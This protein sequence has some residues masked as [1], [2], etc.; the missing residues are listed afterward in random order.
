[1]E[2]LQTAGVIAGI[3]HAPIESQIYD[4][5]R[6]NRATITVDE[7][8]IVS[9]NDQS[10]DTTSAE[11]SGSVGAEKMGKL[12]EDTPEAAIAVCAATSRRRE[13]QN[14]SGAPSWWEGVASNREAHRRARFTDAP[15]D[16]AGVAAEMHAAALPKSIRDG[17]AGLNGGASVTIDGNALVDEDLRSLPDS[18]VD[19]G[20]YKHLSV[21]ETNGEDLIS[22]PFSGDR[23]LPTRHLDS[24]VKL[25][26]SMDQDSDEWA[27]ELAKS[28]KR[29]AEKFDNHGHEEV[30]NA[31]SD[32][33]DPLGRSPLAHTKQGRRN[34]LRLPS[35]PLRD[36]PAPTS[37][38]KDETDESAQAL[39]NANG[40][41]PHEE[42]VPTPSEPSLISS[43][44]KSLFVDDPGEWAASQG[45]EVPAAMLLRPAAMADTDSTSRART[46][47]LQPPGEEWAIAGADGKHRPQRNVERSPKVDTPTKAE[48]DQFLPPLPET[49]QN[50]NIVDECCTE[51]PETG[52]S[53]GS[54]DDDAEIA[55]LEAEV[56]YLQAHRASLESQ[57]ETASRSMLA[58][59]EPTADTIEKPTT[60]DSVPS[61]STTQVASQTAVPM[62]SDLFKANTGDVNSWADVSK[63][64]EGS[65]AP[66]AP[67]VYDDSGPLWSDSFAAYLKEPPRALPAEPSDA[68]DDDAVE[69][70]K[71]TR[72]KKKRGKSKRSSSVSSTTSRPSGT[73][74][75]FADYLKES[76][77]I[78]TQDPFGD[79][80]DDD[81]NDDGTV[82]SKTSAKELSALADELPDLMPPTPL[83]WSE[84]EKRAAYREAGLII[85]EPVDSVAALQSTAS[86]KED[87]LPSKSSSWSFKDAK[88]RFAQKAERAALE[89]KEKYETDFISPNPFLYIYC[90]CPRYFVYSCML[91]TRYESF[92]IKQLR[93]DKSVIVTGAGTNRV[94]GKY[95][96]VSIPNYSSTA[97]PFGKEGEPNMILLRWMR[98]H[99]FL[100]DMGPDIDKVP[101]AGAT[102]Y[103]RSM[104]S[105]AAPP[106][107]GWHPVD[108][109]I[110][111]PTLQLEAASGAVEVGSLAEAV[112]ANSLST[113]TSA[114]KTVGGQFDNDSERAVSAPPVLV[115]DSDKNYNRSIESLVHGS[116]G[117]PLNDSDHQLAAVE[118]TSPPRKKPITTIDDAPRVN[119]LL[120]VDR[121][122]SSGLGF[123]L[124][125]ALNPTRGVRVVKVTPGGL[126]H[127]Q[128]IRVGFEIIEINGHFVKGLG[129]SDVS[130]LLKAAG[131]ILTFRLSVPTTLDPSSLSE[132]TAAAFDKAKKSMA[133]DTALHKSGPQ[134]QRATGTDGAVAE[135]G[136]PAVAHNELSGPLN[137]NESQAEVATLENAVPSDNEDDCATA[138][139]LSMSAARVVTITRRVGSEGG[140]GSDFCQSCCFVL[141]RKSS[142]IH[143]FYY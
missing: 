90:D 26:R 36:L 89:L 1:M 72:R 54:G 111:A 63:P 16:A 42:Q 9:S 18:P 29:W 100:V 133:I 126:T 52:A 116:R 97:T 50:E 34:P 121:H 44:R 138:V 104:C 74:D 125:P 39:E 119:I 24:E 46:P 106:A 43:P 123:S 141:L 114:T 7:T 127:T 32:E 55:A 57:A 91:V 113:Q 83:S 110:P 73:R 143:M 11:N 140:F 86:T 64:K 77:S 65:L 135:E 93:K 88:K 37:P 142:C 118:Q 21:V 13:L 99:W 120:S 128:G 96:P 22:L 25:P 41:V 117:R 2:R 139:T 85:T 78:T 40:A 17:N 105:D 61:T 35:S 102:E 19:K 51:V 10:D 130:N 56:R 58:E 66:A 124:A 134:V 5:H 67:A 20:L 95:V 103:Y 48:N 129:L 131:D 132:A 45:F 14:I 60:D 112:D 79:D 49:Q 81:D 31:V 59:I 33:G 71:I 38:S 92:K 94:N 115:G 62:W 84:A 69:S 107:E 122:G 30:S 53:C 80:G 3:S 6:I 108:G 82:P 12:S 98:D 15:S 68:V 8:N 27:L 76:L 87:V 109:A 4:A 70:V 137:V 101:G 28:G 23:N 75:S 47:P 136:A